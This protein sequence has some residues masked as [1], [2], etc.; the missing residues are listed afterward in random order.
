MFVF[1]LENIEPERFVRDLCDS[2][3]SSTVSKAIESTN[4]TGTWNMKMLYLN[5]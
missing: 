2:R 4:L 3:E 1:N 5:I